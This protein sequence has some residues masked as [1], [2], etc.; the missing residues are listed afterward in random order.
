MTAS[1]WHLYI[2]PAFNL[3]LEDCTHRDLSR[4]VY[5]VRNVSGDQ[6]NKLKEIFSVYPMYYDLLS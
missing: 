4:G 6:P 1:M 2:I 3:F 5:G